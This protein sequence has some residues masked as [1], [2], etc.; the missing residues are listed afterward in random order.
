VTPLAPFVL[1]V[2]ACGC[3]IAALFFARYYRDTR[4]EIFLYF[5]AAFG[6]EAINRALLTFETAPNEASPAHYMIR[7]FGYGLILVGIYRKNL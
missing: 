4:D 7:T 2:L 3:A 6:L 1:G 5:T